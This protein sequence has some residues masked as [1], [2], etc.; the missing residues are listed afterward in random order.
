MIFITTIFVFL[1]A[2]FLVLLALASFFLPKRASMFLNGFAASLRAHLIEMF[3]RLCAGGSLVIVSKRMAFSEWFYIAGWLI[4]VTS[5]LLLLIP[6]KWHN[7]FAKIVVPPLTNRV[8]VFGIFS[9][10]LGLF[11]IFA[12]AV[13]S[14]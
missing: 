5:L 7:A 6:W 14:A 10:P 12:L 4:V 1:F 8:W 3:L 11:I 2:L 9:L 13:G